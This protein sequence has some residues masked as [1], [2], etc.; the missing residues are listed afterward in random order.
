VRHRAEQTQLDLVHIRSRENLVQARTQLINEVR[1]Q[2][3]SLGYRLDSVDAD[4][5]GPQLAK[6]LPENVR[7]ALEMTLETIAQ[8]TGTIHRADREIHQISQRYPEIELLTAIYG[9]GELTALAFVLTIEDAERFGK[10]REVGAYLGMAPG[11]VQSGASDPQQRITKEG[12]R[13]AR[14]LLVQ[15]AH[16]ILRRNAPD[17]D[18]KRWGEKKIREEMGK[19]GRQNSKRKK[20]VLV[21]VARKLAVLMHRLWVHGEVYDPLLTPTRRSRKPRR[22]STR[23]YV[24]ASG[25]ATHSAEFG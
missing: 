7:H 17:S 19:P 6:E 23:K 1:G 22:P 16:C 13:M 10:S 11:Q 9:V 2:A 12:D 3:R 18:L 14:W 5:V 21:A 15:C 25:R 4:Q 8:L 20:R 24:F